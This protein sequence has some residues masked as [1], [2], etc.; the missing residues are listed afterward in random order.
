[1][2]VN[3]NKCSG[4]SIVKTRNVAALLVF[5]L[6]LQIIVCYP[7][8]RFQFALSGSH[9]AVLSANPKGGECKSDSKVAER[10]RLGILLPTGI[11]SAFA[12][13]R[14]WCIMTK[15]RHRK[16]APAQRTRPTPPV[17]GEVLNQP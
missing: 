8:I 2:E 14:G 12:V 11:G 16:T 17:L 7:E 9:Q 13:G 3:V 6:E 1:M 5:L 10:P 15:T 4:S